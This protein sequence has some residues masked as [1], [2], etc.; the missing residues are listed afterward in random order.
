MILFIYALFKQLK[1]N[2]FVIF[3]SS[4]FVYQLN[5]WFLQKKIFFLRLKLKMELEYLKNYVLEGF[6]VPI[7][8]FEEISNYKRFV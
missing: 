5:N 7:N 6:T 3:E 1:R 2:S 4:Q 8:M